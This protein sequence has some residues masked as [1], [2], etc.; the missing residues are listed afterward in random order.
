MHACQKLTFCFLLP[1]L[2]GG[3][4]ENLTVLAWE[5]DAD[6]MLASAL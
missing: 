2:S 4:L 3:T 5:K 1:R 6:E